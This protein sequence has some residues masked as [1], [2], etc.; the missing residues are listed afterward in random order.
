MLFHIM[1][2]VLLGQFVGIFNLG[3]FIWL[4][5][6]GGSI[7]GW[8]YLRSVGSLEFIPCGLSYLGKLELKLDQ[9]QWYWWL[10]VKETYKGKDIPIEA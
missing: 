6:A 10:A 2:C 8:V 1:I 7:L 3:S 4:N 9:N 5:S